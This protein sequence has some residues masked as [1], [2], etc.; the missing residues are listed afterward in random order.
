ML[1]YMSNITNQFK[2]MEGLV[3]RGSHSEFLVHRIGSDAKS[4][5]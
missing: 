4:N 1:K 5:L 2:T 3:L